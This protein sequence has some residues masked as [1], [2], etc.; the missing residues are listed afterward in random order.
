MAMAFHWTM[1]DGIAM[2]A[3]HDLVYEKYVMTFRC[4][5]LAFR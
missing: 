3:E 4:I 2:A 5:S 1:F